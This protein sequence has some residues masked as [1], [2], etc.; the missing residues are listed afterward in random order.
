MNTKNLQLDFFRS[1]T[2]TF[3]RAMIAIYLWESAQTKQYSHSS[4]L[5]SQHKDRLHT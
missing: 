3:K 5:S 1:Y 2:Y 4:V